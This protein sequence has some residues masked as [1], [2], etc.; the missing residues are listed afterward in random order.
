M[1][2]DEGGDL[3][4]VL[5][6][7]Q[8]QSKSDNDG[9]EK[10]HT[11]PG[12]DESRKPISLVV[13]SKILCLA[14]P[15]FKVMLTGNFREARE[16][17]NLNASKEGQT[18]PY[19]IELPEDNPLGMTNLLHLLHFNF[20]KIPETIAVK[21]IEYIAILCDK[22][23]CAH[24]LQ[25]C[26]RVWIN[27][28]IEALDGNP[29]GDRLERN[30]CRLLAF[31]YIAHLPLEFNR[32]AWLLVCTHNGPLL[33]AT[34]K[35]KEVLFNHPLLS[36]DVARHIDTRRQVVCRL[37][38]EAIAAPLNTKW[39][40]LDGAC[41]GA[42]KAIGRYLR[43]LQNIDIACNDDSFRHRNFATLFALTESSDEASQAIRETV[44]QC[45][46][47][48]CDCEQDRGITNGKDLLQ[49]LQDK[50]LPIKGYGKA[51]VCLDCLKTGGESR[52]EG[53][54]KVPHTWEFEEW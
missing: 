53:N 10:T 34:G 21:E 6:E 51:F 2:I 31:A 20:D 8:P 22:Y 38:H 48:R 23:Q 28:W 7:K 49:R 45:T 54:C 15:V 36:Q 52:T 12:S 17:R 47:Y 37:F 29:P 43:W 26:G 18:E 5:F 35:V 11:E 39:K 50:L 46:G 41:F 4:L 32:L 9:G 13:S 25:Y 3:R 44:P 19:T 27:D 42:A 33:A 1:N 40:T 24:I 14:S 16:F 30:I